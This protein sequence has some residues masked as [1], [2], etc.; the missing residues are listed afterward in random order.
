P[1]RAGF[2]VA[3]SALIVLVNLLPEGVHR[4]EFD[5]TAKPVQEHYLDQLPVYV[6]VEVGDVGLDC[7]IRIAPDSGAMANVGDRA[8]PLAIDTGCGDINPGRWN[9]ESARLDI[10]GGIDEFRFADLSALYNLA[11]Y[12]IRA[13]QHSAGQAHPSARNQAPNHARA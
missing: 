2:E 7:E 13:A 3:H 9:D 5:F 1:N 12:F 4:F 8:A 10:R 6:S 11:L